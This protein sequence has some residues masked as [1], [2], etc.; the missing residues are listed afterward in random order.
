MKRLECDLD[1]EQVRRDIVDDQ[2]RAAQV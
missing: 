2:D 1:C